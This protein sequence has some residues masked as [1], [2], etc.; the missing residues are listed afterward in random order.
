MPTCMACEVETPLFMHYIPLCARCN[1]ELSREWRPSR[2]EFH[3]NSCEYLIQDPPPYAIRR[4]LVSMYVAATR[5]YQRDV[6]DLSSAATASRLA[7]RSGITLGLLE[8]EAFWRISRRCQRSRTLCV[9]LRG[10]LRDTQSKSIHHRMI[11][12]VPWNCI[13]RSG[14]LPDASLA[15]NRALA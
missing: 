8:L 13:N 1:R 11:E 7:A 15:E 5:W 10:R 3:S 9:A 2:L 6:A 14:Q 12:A 4:P